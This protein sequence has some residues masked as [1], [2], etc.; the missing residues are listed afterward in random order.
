MPHPDEAADCA[1]RIAE[2]RRVL[3]LMRAEGWETY[4][5]ARDETGSRRAA[6]YENWRQGVITRAQENKQRQR[7]AVHE[8]DVDLRLDAATGRRV[9]GL[10]ARYG[11]S[12]ERL[13]AQL[14]ERAVVTGNTTVTV[15]PFTP[16]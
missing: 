4:E 5:S 13:L 1:T 3:A 6:A 15:P 10:G 14:A 12:P 2:W 7:D 9:R 11:V 16:S 8:L